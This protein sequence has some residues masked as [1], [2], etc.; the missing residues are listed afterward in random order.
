MP[1]G[2]Q[3]PIRESPVDHAPR[4]RCPSNL[5]PQFFWIDTCST[6]IISWASSAA[7]CLSPPTSNVAG[8]KMITAAVVATPSSNRPARRRRFHPL[9][10]RA[11]LGFELAHTPRIPRLDLISYF[12][13]VSAGLVGQLDCGG[14]IHWKRAE[15]G[16]KF[17]E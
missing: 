1:V 9:N 8:Q 12:V 17:K 5:I 14:L 4:G 13:V 15:F 2:F 3:P 7:V 11:L 10:G 6:A 16:L